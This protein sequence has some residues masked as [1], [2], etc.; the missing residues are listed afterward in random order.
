M[1]I[2]SGFNLLSRKR[3]GNTGK[4]YI[5]S[6][7]RKKREKEREHATSTAEGEKEE[8]NRV[9]NGE[10]SHKLQ[11]PFST[12]PKKENRNTTT[13]ILYP[14]RKKRTNRLACTT[15]TMERRTKKEGRLKCDP[16]EKLGT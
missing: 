15:Q 9:A 12:H 5:L 2:S 6:N 14:Q 16:V 3:R 4:I 8:K 11:T 7:R 1:K 10:E 13:T